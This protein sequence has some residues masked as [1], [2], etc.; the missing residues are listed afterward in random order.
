M[1]KVMK[2]Q[3]SYQQLKNGDFLIQNCETQNCE[4]QNKETYKCII[5]TPV[6]RK[7]YIT[8]LY[9]HLCLQKNDFYEWHL[10]INTSNEDDISYINALK[11]ENAWIKCIFLGNEYNNISRFY[12]LANDYNTVYIR[13]DDNIIWLEN[14]FVK[15]FKNFRID[16]PEYFLV[17][18]NIVNNNVIDHIHCRQG[19]VSKF[20]TYKCTGNSWKDGK[21]AY[22]IFQDFLNAKSKNQLH[23]WKFSKWI[24]HQHEQIF[25]NAV[26]WLG[27]NFISSKLTSPEIESL[28]VNFPK[29]YNMKNV[30]CGDI[31]CVH[32]AYQTQL[33]T[34][35]NLENLLDELGKIN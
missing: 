7:T 9:N 20:I 32:Y 6:G 4:T 21:I 26:S 8:Y 33:N 19:C 10:W 1:I 30:I 12:H 34:C 2:N 17:Y 18:A 28:S 27:N 22:E 29:K 24:L 31:L 14:N 5:V 15:R 13:L 11:N 16:N 25:P 3:Y 23:L 35:E